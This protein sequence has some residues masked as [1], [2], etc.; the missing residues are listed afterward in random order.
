MFPNGLLQRLNGEMRKRSANRLMA[1]KKFA[2]TGV[3]GAP[4]DG[5]PA[6]E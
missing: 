2:M 1:E 5:R 6:R 3:E 4:I